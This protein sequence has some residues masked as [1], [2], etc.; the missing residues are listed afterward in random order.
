VNGKYVFRSNDML[1]AAGANMYALAHVQKS[2]ADQLELPVGSYEHI[3]I[4]PHIYYIRDLTPDLENMIVYE[5]RF[6]DY[7][8]KKISEYNAT[9]INLESEM[10]KR[11]R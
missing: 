9:A 3:S 2:I 5:E 7:F 11:R 6:R 10:K 8:N 1:S 4:S